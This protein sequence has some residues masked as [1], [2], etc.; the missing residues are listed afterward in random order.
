MTVQAMSDLEETSGSFRR[1]G[2]TRGS[3]GQTEL[4]LMRENGLPQLIDQPASIDRLTL[5]NSTN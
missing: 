4:D 2:N 1:L 3:A 5:T